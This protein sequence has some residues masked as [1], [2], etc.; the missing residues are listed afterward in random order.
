MFLFLFP[1]WKPILMDDLNDQV[2]LVTE[3]IFQLICRSR[4]HIMNQLLCGN[5]MVFDLS[6]PGHK[7]NF[8]T[9]KYCNNHQIKISMISFNMLI[10]NTCIP[11]LKHLQ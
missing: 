7:W 10:V 11:N 8:L 2:H 4:Q 6:N 5:G 9:G 3:D 1:V